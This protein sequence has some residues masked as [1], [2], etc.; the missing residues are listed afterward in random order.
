MKQPYHFCFL[1][2]TLSLIWRL[3][4]IIIISI[5]FLLNIFETLHVVECVPPLVDNQEI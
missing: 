5:M 1:R 4:I 2:L 3:Y